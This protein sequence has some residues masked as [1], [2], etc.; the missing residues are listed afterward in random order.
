MIAASMMP[1]FANN[2]APYRPDFVR[3]AAF[4]CQLLVL[5]TSL[6]RVDGWLPQA[7]IDPTSQRSK[8]LL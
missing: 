1:S 6:F 2:R 5:R 3:A 7:I 8:T 4:D